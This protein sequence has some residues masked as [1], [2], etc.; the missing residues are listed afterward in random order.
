MLTVTINYDT[1][2]YELSRTAAYAGVKRDD[3]ERLSVTDAD[4]L[5][6]RQYCREACACMVR[7]LKSMV[8]GVSA[9]DDEF[10]LTLRTSASSDS[11]MHPSI[12]S[13]LQSYVALTALTRWL[14]LSGD[15]ASCDFSAVAATMLDDARS[16]LVQRRR[17]TRRIKN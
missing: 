3:Y 8:E 13:A 12:T 15:D 11:T 14:A 6:I 1:V 5:L 16:Q 17:P 2:M 9:G 10:V 4:S 7:S